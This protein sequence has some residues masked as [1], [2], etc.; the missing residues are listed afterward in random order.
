EKEL[1]RC[2]VAL[3][4][5]PVAAEVKGSDLAHVPSAYRVPV[6]APFHSTGAVTS[7]VVSVTIVGDT[8]VSVGC[9]GRLPGRS[10]PCPVLR[11]QCRRCCLTVEEYRHPARRR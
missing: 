6:V 7:S 4:D 1:A 5:G 11:R 2:V 3:Q 9:H 8:T 10:S